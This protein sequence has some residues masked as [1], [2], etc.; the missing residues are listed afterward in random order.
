VVD[1]EGD[2]GRDA[3]QLL[4]F[5]FGVIRGGGFHGCWSTGEKSHVGIIFPALGR[6]V[7]NA[8]GVVGA[9]GL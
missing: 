1:L 3:L 4:Y 9:S 7:H 2:V 6:G 5:T 8:A